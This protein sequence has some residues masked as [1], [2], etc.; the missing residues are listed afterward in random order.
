MVPSPNGIDVTFASLLSE[1]LGES[2]GNTIDTANSR[3][4]PYLVA[5]T[6]IAILA[7]ISFEG[8]LLVLDGQ[9]LVDGL[10]G[11]FEGSAEV[12]LQVVLVD[13]VAGFQVL[14][15]MTDGIAVFDDVFALTDVDN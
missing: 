13:P 5:Y 1:L 7:D 12:G 2:L 10:V 11:V 6:D 14:T 15:C 3:Y 9:W 4:N 8:A